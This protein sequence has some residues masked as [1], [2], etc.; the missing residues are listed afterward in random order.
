MKIRSIINSFLCISLILLFIGFTSSSYAGPNA[1]NDGEANV[2]TE[3]DAGGGD[4]GPFELAAI[5]VIAIAVVIIV[6]IVAI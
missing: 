2:I 4:I 6:A 3:S 1:I 5:V